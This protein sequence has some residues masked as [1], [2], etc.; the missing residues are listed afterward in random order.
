[1]NKWKHTARTIVEIS[2]SFIKNQKTVLREGSLVIVE[3][4]VS[5]GQ[6]IVTDSNPKKSARRQ[7]NLNLSEIK[8]EDYTDTRDI[9]I[10][11]L[12]ADGWD[13]QDLLQPEYRIKKDN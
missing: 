6:Y 3:K 11:M 2:K 10:Q 5:E 4:E 12:L 1:M 13:A 7:Y 8:I 9:N